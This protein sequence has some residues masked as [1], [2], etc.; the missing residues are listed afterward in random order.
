MTAQAVHDDQ[1]AYTDVML[2][3]GMYYIDGNGTRIAINMTVTP[4]VDDQPSEQLYIIQDF[5]QVIYSY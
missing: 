2:E 3:E 1:N 5:K 4:L